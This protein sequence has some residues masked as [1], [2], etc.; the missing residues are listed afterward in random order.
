MIDKFE[1]VVADPEAAW[2]MVRRGSRLSYVATATI[3]GKGIRSE[4]VGLR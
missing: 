3:T 4:G 1:C 2:A